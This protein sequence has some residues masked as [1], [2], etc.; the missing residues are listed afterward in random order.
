MVAQ[1]SAD[2]VTAVRLTVG[3]RDDE[4]WLVGRQ[5]VRTVAP[6]SAP[7]HDLRDRSGFWCELRDGDGRVLHRQ[8]LRDPRHPTDEVAGAR[9]TPAGRVTG[10]FTVLVPVIEGAA[11]VVLV[12]R[13]SSDREPVRVWGHDLG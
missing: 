13:R 4:L 2:D 11:T 10:V 3:Y 8:V 7:L 5:G 6:L 9:H 1:G 12:Q